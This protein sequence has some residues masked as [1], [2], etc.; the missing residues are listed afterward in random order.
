VN[1]GLL[2]ANIDWPRDSDAHVGIAPVRLNVRAGIL[3]GQTGIKWVFELRGG[4]VRAGIS[5]EEQE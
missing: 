5:N 1:G 4:K 2:D 3:E